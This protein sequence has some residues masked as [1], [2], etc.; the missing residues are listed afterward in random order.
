MCFP[1]DD[2]LNTTTDPHQPTACN[3]CNP[4]TGAACVEITARL[5]AAH[6]LKYLEHEPGWARLM[7]QQA[8]QHAA[9]SGLTAPA[10]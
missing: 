9:D 5:A 8:R 2:Q 10:R 7:F 1:V 3:S 4:A 6:R